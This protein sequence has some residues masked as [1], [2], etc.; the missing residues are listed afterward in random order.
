MFLFY[1]C[2]II[3]GNGTVRLVGGTTAN[4]GR[5]EVYLNYFWG[6]VCDHSWDILDAVVVCRQLGYSSV[7]S[8]YGSA[9]F[10]AGTGTIHYGSVA[11]NGTETYLVDCL[12]SRVRYCSHGNDAG[13]VC[14]TRKS[15]LARK[16]HD[17]MMMAAAMV[18]VVTA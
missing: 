16:M 14:D 10:G 6:T 8:A 9:Y 17:M 11:C 1:F 18:V 7:I 5:I 12:H 13:V 4:E 2:A 3:A 15:K